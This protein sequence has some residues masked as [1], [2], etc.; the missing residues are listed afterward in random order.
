MTLGTLAS[1]TVS[2]EIV[3]IDEL[4]SDDGQQKSLVRAVLGGIGPASNTF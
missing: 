3:H 2:G 4:S 1:C